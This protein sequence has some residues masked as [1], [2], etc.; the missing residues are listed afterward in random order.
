MKVTSAEEYGL[1]CLMLLAGRDEGHPLTLTEIS[2]REGLSLPHAGK[3][4]GI[5]KDS[6]LVESVRGRSGGYVLKDPPQELTLSRIFQ[7]LEGLVGLGLFDGLSSPLASPLVTW[8]RLPL[9]RTRGLSPP[10]PEGGPY[11]PRSP[12]PR[13]PMHP[14]GRWPSPS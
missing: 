7:A 3:I 10:W 13:R 14:R 2:E 6:G 9:P 4:M 11:L 12:T 8:R 1:R 5:L